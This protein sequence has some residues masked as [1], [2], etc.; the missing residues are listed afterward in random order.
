MSGGFLQSARRNDA[1]A[2]AAKVGARDTAARI[3]LDHQVNI[4]KVI[5]HDAQDF[6]T[7]G[8]IYRFGK[9]IVIIHG[10]QSVQHQHRQPARFG[11]VFFTRAS[12]NQPTELRQ[13]NKFHPL[14][15]NY[16]RRRCDSLVAIAVKEVVH[17]TFYVC[18]VPLLLIYCV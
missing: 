7:I 4:T 15:E 2:A 10:R 11:G 14:P 12:K 1:R 9:Y 6:S 5:P 3:W 17:Y 18:A 8:P 13:S 16:F